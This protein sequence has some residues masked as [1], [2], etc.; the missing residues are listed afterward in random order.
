MFEDKLYWTDRQL[1]R[2]STCRK[3]RG[4]NQTVVTHM[5][6]QPLGILVSHPSLQP[7]AKNP[8][9]DSPCSHMC[10]L[11][12]TTPGYTCKC[13][14]GYAQDRTTAGGSCMP[15]DYPLLMVMDGS[16]ITDINLRSE[17]ASRGAI[18]AVV[19]TDRGIDFDYDKRDGVVYWI[20]L[21]MDNS[22]NG[23]IYR[24]NLTS[25]NQT[26]F[27]TDS[28]IGAPYTIAF[29]W[30]GRNIYIGNQKAS[31][32]KVI[33][34]DGPVR[35]QRV[36]L[37][38]DGTVNSVARPKS[39]ALDPADG[40]LYWA[41]LGGDNIP[42]KIGRVDM[43]G[44]NPTIIARNDVVNPQCVIVDLSTKN[45]Y[46]SSSAS[47]VEMIDS[48]GNN[49]RV[50]LDSSRGVY[51]PTSLALY[52]SSFFYI[53]TAHEK[54]FKSSM[55]SFD[56]STDITS[57]SPHLKSIKVYTNRPVKENHPCRTNNGGC[58]HI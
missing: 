58:Q 5:V 48:A 9:E 13:P 54:V 6:G 55:P 11:S 17:N 37:G 24:T 46:W 8:C 53:D 49:R 25:G 43:D 26:Q 19:G 2:V 30:V 41:D 29:D 4:T 3:F 22:D 47:K 40:K 1:N 42:P 7:E 32:F 57:E 27:L 56:D 16:Y 10:L 36:I 38:N 44:R 15:I 35:H 45:V 50:I 31:N 23:T 18:S 14:P 20:E 21:N 28:I 51:A 12:P 34:V 39:V 33:K 52:Q